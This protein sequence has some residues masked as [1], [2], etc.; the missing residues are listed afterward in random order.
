MYVSAR[1]NTKTT[2]SLVLFRFNTVRTLEFDPK[3]DFRERMPK[4]DKEKIKTLLF[5]YMKISY[6]FFCIKQTA[7]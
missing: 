1:E 6:I 7:S 2:F 3:K 5:W 4:M